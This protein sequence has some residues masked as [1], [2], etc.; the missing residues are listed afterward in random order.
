MKPSLV[1]VSGLATASADPFTTE[2]RE[3]ATK[4]ASPVNIKLSAWREVVEYQWYG[5]VSV[6]TP[7]QNL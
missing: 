2:H 7:P 5:E 3:R 6:G 1:L 4:Q